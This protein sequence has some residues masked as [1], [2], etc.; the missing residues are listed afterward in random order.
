MTGGP[1]VGVRS[2]ELPFLMTID[3]H[4]GDEPWHVLAAAALLSSIVMPSTFMIP[5]R[6]TRDRS[7]A[8]AI[9]RLPSMGHGVGC[10]GLL[11]ELP[12]D[13]TSDPEPRQRRN[14]VEAKDTLEQVLERPVLCFRAPGCGVSAATFRALEYAGY[15]F[16]LSV[17][18]RRLPFFGSYPFSIGPLLA[19]LG[20]YNPN[21]LSPY[22]RGDLSILE[23]PTTALV[24]PFT[25]MVHVYAGLRFAKGLAKV[26]V[27]RARNR[28]QPLVY[29]GHPADFSATSEMIPRYR[30]LLSDFLPCRLG[31]IRARYWLQ[32]TDQSKVH[33]DNME[34][35]EAFRLL[36]SV[37]FTTVER[38]AA[39][40]A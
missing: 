33:R 19:P 38:Y 10:H 3:V 6:M 12:E 2:T 24:V 4:A 16:D 9:R 21:R 22:R 8:A 7:M 18:A 13:Y 20:P 37:R 30:P 23:I 29:A 1:T 27:R 31:G 35:I 14:L 15:R 5:A 40:L 34:M 25:S 26:L 39:S 28:Q 17:C 32:E 36:P 11:H